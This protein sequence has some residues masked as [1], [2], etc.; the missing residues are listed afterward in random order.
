MEEVHRLAKMVSS[1]V[2]LQQ[3]SSITIKL[4]LPD[5]FAIDSEKIKSLIYPSFPGM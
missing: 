5:S 1:V 3:T 4:A 2:N